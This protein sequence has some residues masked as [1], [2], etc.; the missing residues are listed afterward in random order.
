MTG[1]LYHPEVTHYAIFTFL[2]SRVD[3]TVIAI[4]WRK[5]KISNKAKSLD[6]LQQMSNM[7]LTCLFPSVK[8]DDNTLTA[9]HLPLNNRI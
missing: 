2:E 5:M 4:Q 9:E 1:E 3:V 6:I 7:K 8:H